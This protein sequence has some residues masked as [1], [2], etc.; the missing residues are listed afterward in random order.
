[1]KY[2]F[3]LLVLL[4][5]TTACDDII[6]VED[7]SNKKVT[8]LAPTNNATLTASNI[9]F[10]WQALE[11]AEQYNIQIATP[12]FENAI[13]IV[14]DSSI[15][16]TNYTKTIEAGNYQWRVNAKNSGFQTVYTTQSFLVE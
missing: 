8:I 14:L 5:I 9:T 12:D 13:Q 6:E 15:T 2:T 1:M 11:D 16:A 3:T 4:L 10:S 7:I